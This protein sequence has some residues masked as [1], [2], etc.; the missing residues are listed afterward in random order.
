M[1]ALNLL[2]VA[3]LMSTLS[4]AQL[5]DKVI[6]INQNGVFKITA[7]ITELKGILE[8]QLN[9]EGNTTILYKIAI[10]K[11]TIDGS[12]GKV[13]YT[14]AA[15]NKIGNIKI[16]V[17]ISLKDSV[18][19][20][21]FSKSIKA[22]SSYATCFGGC[23]N[24]CSPKKSVDDRGNIFWKCTDCPGRDDACKKSVTTNL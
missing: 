1:K 13:Y 18:F 24:G 6:G 5:I 12:G 14:I 11:D 3:M 8:A 9:R 21:R 10:K 15:Q 20:A 7:D 19:T 23:I 2:I 17:D 4:F 22:F 16:A